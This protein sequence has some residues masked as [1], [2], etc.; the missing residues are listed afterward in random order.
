MDFT[1]GV[2]ALRELGGA[3]ATCEHGEGAPAKSESI[4]VFSEEI[5]PTENG[6]PT[7]AAVM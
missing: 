6:V 7:A 4:V 3:W 5:A 2:R 1:A